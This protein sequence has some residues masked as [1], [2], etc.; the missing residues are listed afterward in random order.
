M[1]I[2]GGDTAVWSHD[3]REVFYRVG[4]RMIVVEVE[5][6]PTLRVSPPEELW[7]EAYYDS[8]FGTGARQYHVAPEGRFLMIRQG[9]ATDD[10]SA[11][12]EIN[13]RRAT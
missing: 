11:P 13:D 2:G 4:N 1:S 10:S 5:T 12:P 3:G 7:E 9:A 8:G 6:E